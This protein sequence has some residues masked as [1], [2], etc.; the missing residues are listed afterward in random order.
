MSHR[1][2]AVFTSNVQCVRFD[3]GRN[4]LKMR[5][6]VSRFV[7]NC[8]FQDTDFPQGCEATQL[9][10]GLIFSDSIITNVLL[11]QTVK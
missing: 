7:F 8:C 9:T 2:T 10:C 11:I 6:Y 3:A 1:S 4:T 5:F